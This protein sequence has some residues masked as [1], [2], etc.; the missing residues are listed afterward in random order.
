MDHKSLSSRLTSARVLLVDDEYYMRK[1]V[2]TMLLGLGI[3]TVYEAEDGATGPRARSGR[4]DP[5]LGNAGPERRLLRAP[6][7][8]ARELPAAGH[9]DHHADRPRRARP[10]IGR[11]S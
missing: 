11:A 2:R 6:R 4:G 8:Y 10:Q 3:R 7:A 9:S 5:R 1:V